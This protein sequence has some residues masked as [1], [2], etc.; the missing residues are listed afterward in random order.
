MLKALNPKA[1]KGKQLFLSRSTAV[2]DKE[3]ACSQREVTSNQSIVH[4]SVAYLPHQ[5]AKNDAF[6]EAEQDMYGE[7]AETPSAASLPV[8]LSQASEFNLV[9]RVQG[10]EE[11]PPS[12][13]QRADIYSDRD[14]D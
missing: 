11:V 10:G 5:R 14:G 12:R 6:P 13:D 8:Q 3:P 2:L 9:A 1:S 4:N 7:A